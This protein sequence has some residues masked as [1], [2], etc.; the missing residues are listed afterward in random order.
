VRRRSLRSAVVVAG[1]VASG[2]C[3]DGGDPAGPR[4]GPLP[5]DAAAITGTDAGEPDGG[6]FN[7]CPRLL[8]PLATPGDDIGGDD[9]ATFA[10]PFFETFCVRC[11]ATTVVG[12]AREGAPDGRDWDEAATLRMFLPEIRLWVGEVNQMP[13][14]DPQPS[15]DERRRLVRWIDAGAP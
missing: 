3:S 14:G 9:Y 12:M 10:A 11:H 4:E 7:G 8:D 6:L 2:G 5:F 13:I 15:C 1:L